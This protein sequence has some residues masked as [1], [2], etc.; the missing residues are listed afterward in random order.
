MALLQ[1]EEYVCLAY[2]FRIQ[3]G[4]LSFVSSYYLKRRFMNYECVWTASNSDLTVEQLSYLAT[5][6]IIFDP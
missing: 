4:S 5:S 1:N 2:V 6:N 3:W